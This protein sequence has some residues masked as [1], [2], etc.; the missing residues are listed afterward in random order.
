MWWLD[1]PS[2]ILIIA[3]ALVLGILGL[4]DVNIIEYLLGDY[5][6]IGYVVFGAAGVWQSTRQ[7]FF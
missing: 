4:T 5:A 3:A 2:L 1:F 6:R 7:R